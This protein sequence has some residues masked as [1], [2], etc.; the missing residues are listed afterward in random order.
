MCVYIYI[1]MI[2]KNSHLCSNTHT[3]TLTCTQ[4]SVKWIEMSFHMFLF[5]LLMKKC[6]K[7]SSLP[8]NNC[9]HSAEC[10]VTTLFHSLSLSLCALYTATSMYANLTFDLLRLL[11]KRTVVTICR[12]TITK[13]KNNSNFAFKLKRIV[14]YVTILFKVIF[15]I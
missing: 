4:T 2:R 1:N 6:T 11:N 9:T 14:R 5:A 7:K 13:Q 10:D 15:Y 12:K 8:I 3:Q